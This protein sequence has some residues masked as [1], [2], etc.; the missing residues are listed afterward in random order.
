MAF[1]VFALLFAVSAE[2]TTTTASPTAQ[3]ER[4]LSNITNTTTA[5]PT[6]APTPVPTAAPTPEPT[7]A[8]TP[9]PLPPVEVAVAYMLDEASFTALKNKSEDAVFATFEASFAAATGI[10]ANAVEVT[11]M[12]VDGEPVVFMGRRLSTTSLEVS[13][14]I[15]VDGETLEDVSNITAGIESIMD[16]LADALV[17][18]VESSLE[19]EGM[20]VEVVPPGFEPEEPKKKKKSVKS[21]AYLAC[22]AVASL[23]W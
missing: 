2:S 10:D 6:P 14:A 23:L 12:T 5:A 8:P 17:A 7:P 21:G 15:A 4:I 3:E 13:Y 18:E 9:T 11:N 19:I 16:D 22:V 20:A 1:V